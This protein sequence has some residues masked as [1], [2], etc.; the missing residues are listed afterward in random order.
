MDDKL[1]ISGE[2][3]RRHKVL[4]LT[5]TQLQI[6]LRQEMPL[7]RNGLALDERSQKIVF[8]RIR[9]CLNFR[10]FLEAGHL[11]I[12]VTPKELPIDAVILLAE[13]YHGLP[14][15]VVEVVGCLGV[16]QSEV[17]HV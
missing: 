17:L 1:V 4:L 8:F 6:L 13:L 12:G 5:R 2:T 10:H 3:N 16:G 7:E 15:I 11:I 9:L 14:N